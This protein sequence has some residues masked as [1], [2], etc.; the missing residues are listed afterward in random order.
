MFRVLKPDGKLVILDPFTNGPLRKALCA[1]LDILYDENGT[2]LFT[3]EQMYQMFDMAGFSH[4][5]QKTYWGYKL[6]TV[7]VK[8]CEIHPTLER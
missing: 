5:V 3:Q 6:L 1:I 7:G 2:N 8:T 4:I